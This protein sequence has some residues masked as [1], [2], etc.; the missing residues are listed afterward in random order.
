M[1]NGVIK[2]R[3]QPGIMTGLDWGSL[4]RQAVDMR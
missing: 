4:Y 2:L 1:A 3:Q